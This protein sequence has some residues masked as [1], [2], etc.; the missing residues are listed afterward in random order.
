MHQ[1]LLYY[2]QLKVFLKHS[3]LYCLQSIVFWMQQPLYSLQSI[4]FLMHQ[5]LY[6]LQLK[7]FLMQRPLYSLQL[8]RSNK[9]KT[10]VLGCFVDR[11][12]YNVLYELKSLLKI[13][14]KKA[15]CISNGVLKHF[16]HR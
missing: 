6:S 14:G 3:P 10:L 8:M 5:P 7:L 9:N 4:V 2:R 11:S 15:F 13:M 16:A 1:P 12:G